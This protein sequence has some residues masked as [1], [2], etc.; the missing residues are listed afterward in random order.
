MGLQFRRVIA[1]IALAT[2]GLGQPAL[3]DLTAGFDPPE[4]IV[5]LGDIFT[6][7]IVA[8]IPDPIVGWGLDLAFDESIISLVE[9]PTI[10]PAWWPPYSA[11][12]GDGLAALA[13]PTGI[14]G[15]DILLATLTFSADALG[16][17]D[18]IL[19]ATPGD[20]AEGFALDPTG[21]A[22]VT[23]ELGHVVV[24]P[25]PTAVLLGAVGLGMVGWMKR[26]HRL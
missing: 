7:D 15:T 20:L 5:G 8:D 24:V 22:D 16:E 1:G 26:R 12:D 2:L 13:F 10:G 3:G 19:S 17:T 4:T 6:I 18:L 23:F 25:G 9:A 21:F 14:S 11:P